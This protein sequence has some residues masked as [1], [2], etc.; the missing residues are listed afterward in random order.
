MSDETKNLGRRGQRR[1]K[2]EPAAAVPATPDFT[3]RA[4]ITFDD[5]ARFTGSLLPEMPC[6]EALDLAQKFAMA[7]GLSFG[8]AVLLLFHFT[9]PSLRH[10]VEC[11]VLTQPELQAE[12]VDFLNPPSSAETE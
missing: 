8:W 9:G 5:G 1:R 6:R 4:P 10:E 7:E 12:L 2:A 11:P 3:S